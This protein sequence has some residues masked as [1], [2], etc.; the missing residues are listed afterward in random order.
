M[1]GT[2]SKISKQL[3]EA[4]TPQSSKH[5]EIDIVDGMTIRTSLALEHQ[6]NSLRKW[7]ISH[8]DTYF[9]EYKTAQSSLNNEVGHVKQQYKSIVVEPVLPNLIYILTGALTGSVV[10]RRRA[11]PVRFLAPLAV[12]TALYGYLMPQSFLNTRQWVWQNEKEKVPEVAA[13]H[14]QALIT[15]EETKKVT[16]EKLRDLN[17]SLVELIH[18]IRQYI[19]DVL[20]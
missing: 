12:G 3:Y 14:L 10:V 1:P 15:I 4:E 18:N 19:N 16:N 6:L 8:L 2:N 5:T 9:Y 11:L 17:V 7:T 13:Q 20:N